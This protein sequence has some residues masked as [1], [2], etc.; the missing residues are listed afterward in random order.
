MVGPDS[1]GLREVCGDGVEFAVQ[2]ERKG[3]GH[4]VKAARGRLGSYRGPVLVMAGDLPLLRPQT[5]RRLVRSHRQTGGGMAL[6]T[7]TVEDAHGW[8][9]IVRQGR[10]VAGIV[11]ERD[12]T[13]T[14]RAIRE[15]NVGVYCLA[16]PLLFDLLRKIKPDNAQNELY[17]TDI[18]EQALRRDLQVG[19]VRVDVA[20]VGQINSRKQ[21]AELEAVYRAQ[22]NDRWMAA[23]VTLIDPATTYIGPDVR[24]GRD[25]VIGP[26]VQLRGATRIG[27]DCQLDGSSFITDS[28]IGDGV[29]LRFGCV[30]TEA[31]VGRDCQIGPFAHLRPGSQ[32]GAGVHIG[33]FVETKNTR[34]ADGAKANHLAYLGDADI[35]SETNVG[36]G[37]ITCNYDGFNKY[38]TVVG[39]RVMIGSDTQLVAPVRVADDS[40]IATGTTVM[41]DVGSGAL[42]FNRRDQSERPGWVAAKRRSKAAEASKKTGSRRRRG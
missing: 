9:R 6:L 22:I 31:K 4:A 14:Q 37:T 12:A 30:L 15:V 32:L 3:T 20:E 39:K 29:H 16:A 38:R 18:V 36:A 41:R 8:G 40:Y 42:V 26:N 24:I 27:R 28:L 21:L 11:E 33:D 17:L 35:G 34:L 13:P 10:R 19:S 25:S 2:R 5:I 23:G 7:A 1:E